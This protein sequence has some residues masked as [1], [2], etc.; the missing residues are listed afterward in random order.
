M[1]IAIQRTG[2]LARAKELCLQGAVLRGEAGN[3]K[4][5]T[6]CWRLHWPYARAA[7]TR[8]QLAWVGVATRT[9]LVAVC[10]LSPLSQAWKARA[11]SVGS[12]SQCVVIGHITR[13]RVPEGAYDRIVERRAASRTGVRTP[14]PCI[15]RRLNLQYARQVQKQARP[16]RFSRVESRSSVGRLFASKC[17]ACLREGIA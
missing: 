8:R 11:L 2:T 12:P 16:H 10:C 6:F 4:A 1:R 17:K 15:H 5:K 9:V 14:N 3:A 13:L 7:A